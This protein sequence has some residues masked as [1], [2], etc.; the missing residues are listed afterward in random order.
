MRLLIEFKQDSYGKLVEFL[1]PKDKCLIK[2]KLTVLFNGEICHLFLHLPETCPKRFI[3]DPNC[4]DWG[5]F[6]FC[7]YFNIKS[8][9][10]RMNMSQ[11]L[12]A[13]TCNPS[14]SGGI[15]QEDH[16]SKPA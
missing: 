12:V 11:A 6:V 5:S 4:L 8:I 15:D 9:H 16:S 13:H 14:N 7:S 2:S 10:L 3:T 1:L